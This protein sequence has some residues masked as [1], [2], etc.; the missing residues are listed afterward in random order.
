MT[1]PK[2][3]RSPTTSVFSPPVIQDK[4]WYFPALS[5]PSLFH[6]PGWIS[7]DLFENNLPIFV[8]F[9]SGNGTWIAEKAIQFPQINWLAVEKRFDRTRKIWSKIKN[10]NLKNLVV[11]CAEGLSLSK[12]FFPQSSI[13]QIF[14]NFPDP[15]PKKRHAKHRFIS[16]LL[17]EEASRT[18]QDGGLLTLVTDDESSSELFLEL[19]KS[20]T[21][22]LINTLSYPGYKSPP[23]DYGTSF[24]DSLFRNQGKE[25]RYHEIAKVL[26]LIRSTESSFVK[27]SS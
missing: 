20:S 5:D 10:C 18:L 23:E 13:K 12:H 2:D 15:W 4:V 11:A 26:S 7:S 6:F 9:C 22:P 24:F 3:L 25:I 14:V 8:E 17:F 19:A 1:K 27:S 16:P 21:L